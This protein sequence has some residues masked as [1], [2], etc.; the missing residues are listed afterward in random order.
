MSKR[1]GAIG[2]K[3]FMSA[4]AQL[5][6][7]MDVSKMRNASRPVQ[8]THGSAAE[9]AIRDWIGSYLP[10][11]YAVTSGFVVPD[12]IASEYKL[13][14]FDV[15]IY[16]QTESPI[17]W[18][19]R[20]L[21][22]SHEG[23][24]LAIPAQYVKAVLEVKSSLNHEHAVAAVTKLRQLSFFHPFLPATFFSG[25]VFFELNT[26]LLNQKQILLDLIPD[27]LVP[28]YIGGVVLRCELNREM[29]GEF[30]LLHT[31]DKP[32][33]RKDIDIAL[34][35]DLDK[36]GIHRN[37]KGQVTISE[38]GAGVQAYSDGKE[39]HFTKQYGPMLHK[40]STAIQLQWSYNGFASFAVDLL[41]RIGGRYQP[42]RR[43]V[44][45]GQAFDEIV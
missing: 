40:G 10:K 31:S 43:Q 36:I 27:D 42:G 19:D 30:S 38:Q 33:E 5:L 32:E 37:E 35:K 15:I 44:N 29:T 41:L 17:L 9:A 39:W 45:F 34:A 26:S 2:W 18:V 21:D 4:R 1:Y 3:E 7:A 13:Y 25:I 23:A 11:R 16:D 20:D 24:K 28:G 14:E 8:T 22:R 6:N 12:V